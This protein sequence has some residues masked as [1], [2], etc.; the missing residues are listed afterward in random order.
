MTQLCAMIYW[1][2]AVDLLHKVPFLYRPLNMLEYKIVN[3]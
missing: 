2:E 3:L 1:L